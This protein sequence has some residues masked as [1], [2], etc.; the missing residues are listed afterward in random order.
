MSHRTS[1]GVLEK[2]MKF[3]F[4]AIVY[5]QL[6]ARASAVEILIKKFTLFSDEP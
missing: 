6:E 4:D 3:S 2:T 1:H 5:I